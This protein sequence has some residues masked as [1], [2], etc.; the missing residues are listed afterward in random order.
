[1]STALQMLRKLESIDVDIAAKVSIDHTKKH[2]ESLQKVQLFQG[3]GSDDLAIIP[4]YTKRTKQIKIS[5]GQP[6]DRVTLRDTGDF[7]RGIRIDVVG[8]AIRTDSI[9][10]K[11]RD[12]QLKYGEEIFGLGTQARTRYKKI[13]QPEFIKQIKAYLR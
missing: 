4:S 9:D 1:M 12:L 3:I 13:L 2:A 10:H 7:Y 5:K 11:S 8:E 6:I